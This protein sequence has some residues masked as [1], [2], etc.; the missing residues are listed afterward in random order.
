MRGSEYVRANDCGRL[1]K[2]KGDRPMS[3]PTTN[4]ALEQVVDQASPEELPSLF[5]RLVSRLVSASGSKVQ[6]VRGERGMP[7]GV[8]IPI[9]ELPPRPPMTE[10]EYEQLAETIR[11]TT[12]DQLISFEEMMRRLG[13]EDVHQS[14]K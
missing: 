3:K 13:L 4:S 12:D 10:A 8:F 7:I 2:T 11:N 14:S 6:T 9:P 1:R 5:M